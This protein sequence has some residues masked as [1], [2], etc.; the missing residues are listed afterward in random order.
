MRV[1]GT[2][3]HVDHGKSTLVEALTG[4]HPDRLKEEQERE[5]TIDLGFAWMTLPDGEEVGIVDVPGHRDFVENML[6][7]VGGID[8]A[9]FVVAADEGVMPQTREHLAILDILQIQGGVVALTKTDLFSRTDLASSEWLD[10][11]EE[12][13]RHALRDTVLEEAPIVRVSARSGAGI[14]D[15][16]QVLFESLANK[17][18]RPDYGR[19]RLPVDRVFT[20]SGF[21]TVVTGTLID[22]QLRVGDEVELLPGGLRGRVRGLQT[23]KRKEAVA[24]PAS[25]TA[26]NITGVNV[27]QIQRGDV[28][29][30]P[31]DY[32]PTRRIDVRFRLL[33]DTSQAIKHNTQVKLFIGSAEI[34]ARLRLLGIELLQPGEEGWLQLELRQPVVAVRGDHY[35]L[36]RPSPAETLGGGTVVDPHPKG[37]HKRF[38]KNVL[39]RLEALSQGTPAEVMMESLAALGAAPLREVVTRASLPE[40]AANKAIVELQESGQLI[41]LEDGVKNLAPISETLVAGKSYWEQM[42]SRMVQIVRNYHETYPLRRGMQKEELKS[43]LKSTARLFNAA[44]QKLVVE[45]YLAESGPLVHLPDHEIRFSAQQERAIQALLARF[46]A[47]PFTPPTVKE[48]QAEVGEEIYNALTELRI[49]LPVSPEV[50]FRRE[51][52]EQMVA[53]VRRLLEK[54]ETISAAQVRDH[55]DTSRRYALA[56]LEHLD[57]VGVTVREG[58][59]RRLKK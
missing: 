29:A 25:R 20:I 23:H 32:T 3:G 16:M 7:G 11:V 50:V 48:A 38:T 59:V 52:Y 47:S 9:L 10:L 41:N 21:G 4:T 12:D 35:I 1:I 42:T 53:E 26:V 19:P 33:P 46:K 54:N 18:V 40:A 39:A 34:V 28:L 45:G 43:R 51:I 56:L 58:D 17:P 44:M 55:F 24:V 36:R 6:A 2:A 37:R 30:H 27:D 5:M 15:L 13:V 14:E 57:K 49:L 31:G 8:A 22:G